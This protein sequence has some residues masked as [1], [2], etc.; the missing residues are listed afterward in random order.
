MITKRTTTPVVFFSL[1]M[2]PGAVG[3][4]QPVAAQDIQVSSANPSAAPRGTINLDVT[5]K[6]KNFKRGAVSSKCPRQPSP[7]CSAL[8]RRGASS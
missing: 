3:G 1:L 7:S 8:R 2:F 5:I 6:G 4:Q